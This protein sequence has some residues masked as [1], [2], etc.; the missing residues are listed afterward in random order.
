MIIS[1]GYFQEFCENSICLHVP[2]R[3]L[4]SGTNNF[5]NISFQEAKFFI[6]TREWKCEFPSRVDCIRENDITK[7]GQRLNRTSHS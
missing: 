3:K 4:K 2:V 1:F 5:S 6:C 7:I